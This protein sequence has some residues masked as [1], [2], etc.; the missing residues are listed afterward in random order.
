MNTQAATWAQSPNLQTT[1]C[2]Q[3]Q[4][5]AHEIIGFDEEYGRPF[6]QG[7]YCEPCKWW[8]AAILRERK[9]DQRENV[10]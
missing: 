8:K 4:G 3:C 6:R 9:V 1:T 5:K 10:K 2:E 7:W